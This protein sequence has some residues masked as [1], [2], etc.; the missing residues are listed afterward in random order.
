M[1]LG[2]TTTSSG[3]IRQSIRLNLPT[4]TNKVTFNL[5]TTMPVKPMCR[6]ETF[7]NSNLSEENASCFRV[8]NSRTMNVLRNNVSMI[9]LLNCAHWRTLANSRNERKL[10]FSMKHKC[11]Q[12]RS[13][14]EVKLTLNRAV[15]ICRS[16]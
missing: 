3:M 14:W 10:V 11:I 15:D 7:M 8:T 1:H 9:A 6:E 12:E 16:A 4:P 2:V 5:I 13:L